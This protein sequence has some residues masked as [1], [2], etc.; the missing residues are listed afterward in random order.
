MVGR[1]RWT[2]LSDGSDRLDAEL[3]SDPETAADDAE[4]CRGAMVITA[5]GGNALDRVGESSASSTALARLT[6][7][8]PGGDRYYDVTYRLEPDACDRTVQACSFVV[9]TWTK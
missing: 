2:L 8:H 7:D 1:H 9:E 3:R 4:D 5:Y 6:L